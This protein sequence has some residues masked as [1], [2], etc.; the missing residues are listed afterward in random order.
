ML[1]IDL[2]GAVTGSD[3]PCPWRLQLVEMQQL[4]LYFVP[5]SPLRLVEEGDMGATLVSSAWS[6]HRPNGV[7]HKRL[8]GILAP[9]LMYLPPSP[10]Q[11]GPRTGA[12]A[13]RAGI[14]S[15][16][17]EAAQ[18]GRAAAAGGE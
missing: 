4:A 18:Q 17:A 11:P 1:L 9:C 5:Q 8:V 14:S 10:L 2:H 3:L 16:R 7:V 6:W 15:A 12:W 13:H